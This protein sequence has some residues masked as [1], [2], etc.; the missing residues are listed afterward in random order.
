MGRPFWAACVLF[1][2]YEKDQKTGSGNGPGSPEKG[3]AGSHCK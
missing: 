3:S 1:F 2:L